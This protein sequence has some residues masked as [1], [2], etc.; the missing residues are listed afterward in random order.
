MNLDKVRAG[1]D[2]L[3]KIDYDRKGFVSEMVRIARRWGNAFDSHTYE[4]EARQLF[5][6]LVDFRE[7]KARQDIIDGVVTSE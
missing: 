5:D 3:E 1:A 7:R 2:V 6:A 4:A